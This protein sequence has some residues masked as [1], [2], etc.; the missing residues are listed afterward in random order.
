MGI[1][2]Y[3]IFEIKSDTA[4]FVNDILENTIHDT[5]V[6]TVGVVLHHFKFLFPTIAKW[7]SQQID[8]EIQTL[9]VDKVNSVEKTLCL[10]L[11]LT[12]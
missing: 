12:L 1:L 7:R 9:I 2:T 11:T 10:Y 3:S 4:T 5:S 6:D 8:L